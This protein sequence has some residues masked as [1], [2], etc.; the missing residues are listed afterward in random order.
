TALVAFPVAIRTANKEMRAGL[1]DR[2]ALA[3]T[4]LSTRAGAAA[5]DR[6]ARQLRAQKVEV[7]LI[8]DGRATP[9]DG[10]PGALPAGL[11]AK[12]AAGQP[13]SQRALVGGRLL[14][15]EGRPVPGAT[16]SGIVLGERAATGT[17]AEVWSRLWLPLL[18]GLL[19]GVVA[20]FLLAKLLARPIRRAAAAAVRLTAGDRSVRVRP[21]P[22]AEVAELAEAL[23]ALA[24]ALATSE[25]RQREFLLSVSHELRTPLTTIKGYAEAL[26]DGVVGPDGAQRAGQ[27]MLGEAAHLDRLVADLLALARLEAAE[28]PLEIMPVDLAQVVRAAAEAWGG[29]CAAVGV[30]LRTEVPD[31]PVPA[32]TDPGR[33]RQILDGLLE[34][35]L[36]VV[37]PGAPV[38]LAALALPGYALLEVRDGGPGFTD[39]DLAVAFERGALSERYRGVR[40]VGSGLGLA[41]ASGLTRRMGGT[42]EAGHAAEGGARFTVRLPVRPGPGIAG[43]GPG[44]TPV[45][46][47][48]TRTSR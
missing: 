15:L 21:E 34:N 14:L 13:V 36:R 16:G 26:A 28:F 2:A 29:R 32:H 33:V 18:A 9:V 27:T 31:R 48:R 38:V 17:R 45:D 20:G 8:A 30:V 35:A 1:A 46:P 6:L 7:W 44:R 5:Q 42:I 25:G 3:A 47:Y 4:A 24:S 39:A 41:I 19:A 37:P 12:V 43:G 22:P 40:K 11:V 10:S 23:N